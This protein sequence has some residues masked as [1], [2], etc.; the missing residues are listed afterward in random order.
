MQFFVTTR[1][2]C[3]SLLR[4]PSSVPG[5]DGDNLQ[6]HRAQVHAVALP[7]IEVVGDGDSAA[8]S[9]AIPDRDV[10]VEGRKYAC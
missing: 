3:D 1:L 10:L 5:L 9:T 2:V 7:S 8:R 6:V 4:G